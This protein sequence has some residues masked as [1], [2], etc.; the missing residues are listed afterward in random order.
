MSAL[1]TSKLLFFCFDKD[2]LVELAKFYPDDFNHKDMV[3]LE[4]EL[5]LYIDHILMQG[6]VAW[7][8]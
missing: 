2:K 4:H 6:F 7:R 1:S 5:L 3:T 8:V